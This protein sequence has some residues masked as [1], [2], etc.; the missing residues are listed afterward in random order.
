MLYN[1]GN[2]VTQLYQSQQCQVGLS[3]VKNWQKNAIPLNLTFLLLYSAGN[4]QMQRV[5]IVDKKA[6]CKN[7]QCEEVTTLKLAFP[8]VVYSTDTSALNLLLL[9]LLRHEDM[10]VGRWSPRDQRKTI[11]SVNIFKG[12]A[13]LRW[14]LGIDMTLISLYEQAKWRQLK[15][16]KTIGC[17]S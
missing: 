15:A 8:V 13:G 4:V 12:K 3:M 1:Q 2:T 14:T 5:F 6:I 16:M 7:T 10:L 9:L 11:Q 17:I